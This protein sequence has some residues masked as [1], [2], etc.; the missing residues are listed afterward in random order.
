MFTLHFVSIK[1]KLLIQILD[2]SICY[3]K[4][5]HKLKSI[6]NVP[7]YKLA[8]T[9]LGNVQQCKFY[10]FHDNG[11]IVDEDYIQAL[12]LAQGGI[13]NLTR[14]QQQGRSA[15]NIQ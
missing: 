2:K 12:L 10:N 4:H 13:S 15:G 6:N 5:G 14:A 8:S 7:N 9:P 1:G 3:W 11:L